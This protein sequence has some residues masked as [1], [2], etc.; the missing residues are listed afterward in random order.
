MLNMTFGTPTTNTPKAL[1]KPFF[2][3]DIAF[4]EMPLN[5]V[6]AQKWIPYEM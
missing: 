6:S 2:L 5:V 1:S 4:E 3:V